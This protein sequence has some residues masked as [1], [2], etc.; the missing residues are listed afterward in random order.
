M[1]RC[2]EYMGVPSENDKF[3]N[4][5]GSKDWEMVLVFLKTCAWQKRYYDNFICDGTQWELKAKG[6][7]FNI[8]SYGSN[9]YPDNFKEFVAT[10][11]KLLAVAGIRIA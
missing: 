7:G 6:V 3:V 2:S 4:V 5:D 8:K 11:N 9:S 1:L 10:I